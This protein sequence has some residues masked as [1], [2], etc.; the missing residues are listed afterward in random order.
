LIRTA[1]SLNNN[2]ETS[3]ETRAEKEEDEASEGRNIALAEG[4]LARSETATDERRSATCVRPSFA[5][6]SATQE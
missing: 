1:A 4:N 6:H 3:A 5:V 2:A